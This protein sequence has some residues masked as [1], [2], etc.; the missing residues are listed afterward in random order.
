MQHSSC[1]TRLP[2]S[3]V[4]QNPAKKRGGQE[5]K[6]R[7]RAMIVSR[8]TRFSRVSFGFVNF[9]FGISKV[10]LLDFEKEG[11]FLEPT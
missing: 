11:K 5:K 2:T 8:W 9:S 10:E 7:I 1:V 6:P 4:A 3:G